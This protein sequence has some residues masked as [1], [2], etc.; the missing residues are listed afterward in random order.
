MSGCGFGIWHF[1]GVSELRS[2][3]G[4]VGFFWEGGWGFVRGASMVGRRMGACEGPSWL[5]LQLQLQQG[6]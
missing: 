2:V 4:G 5:D 1:L 3:F 6:D